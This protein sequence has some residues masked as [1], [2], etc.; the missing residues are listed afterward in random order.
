[1]QP[2]GD[3]LETLRTLLEND[4]SQEAVDRFL[5]QKLRRQREKTGKGNDKERRPA[6]EKNGGFSRR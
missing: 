3:P 6:P 2:G 4:L 5:V 1:M